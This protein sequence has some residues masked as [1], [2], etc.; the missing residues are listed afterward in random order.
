MIGA[1]GQRGQ[2]GQC[3]ADTALAVV[4]ALCFLGVGVV[5]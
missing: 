5:E 3:I 1:S 4:G 2:Q